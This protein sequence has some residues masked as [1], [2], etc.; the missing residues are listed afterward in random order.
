MNSKKI[1][2]FPDI[3][4][5]AHVA[6]LLS[7]PG[8]PLHL[9]IPYGLLTLS[10]LFLLKKGRGLWQRLQPPLVLAWILLTWVLYALAGAVGLW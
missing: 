2:F 7:V 3:L 8:I 6:L 1:S 10:L 9:S 5:L 4:V